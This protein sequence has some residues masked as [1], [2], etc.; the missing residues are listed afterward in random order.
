MLDLLRDPIW[1][2][3]AAIIAIIGT[4]LAL[5]NFLFPKLR[6]S[7][8]DK[9]HKGPLL[10]V[11]K[12][13]Q[14]LSR[15]LPHSKASPK[16]LGKFVL[17]VMV[18][19]I[20]LYYILMPPRQILGRWI[21]VVD[22]SD[23]MN[24]VVGEKSKISL[25]HEFLED[26]DIP[27]GV[28]AGLRIFGGDRSGK[29]DCE[30]TTLLI[31]P[32]IRQQAR[33][34]S[35][36]YEITVRGKTP[37]MKAIVEATNDF[38]L[39]STTPNKLIIL[40]SGVDNCDDNWSND[41]YTLLARLE[42]KSKPELHLIGVNIEETQQLEQLKE[43]AYLTDGLYYDVKNVEDIPD[44]SEAIR[45]EKNATYYMAR[46]DSYYDSGEY[47]IAIASYNEAIR[48]DAD[49][50]WAYNNRGN[51]YYRKGEFD[52]AISEFN[53]A[54]ADYDRA[55][56]LDPSLVWVY[57][58][59]GNAYNRTGEYDQAITDYNEAIELNSNFANAHS[60]RGW[61]YN[62]KGEY[63]KA[64]ADL[65]RAISL[66]PD[67][68][69]AYNNRGNSYYQKG[70]YDKAIMDLSRSIDLDSDLAWAYLNRGNSYYQRGEFDLAIADY[71]K[72]LEL[73]NNL[74]VYKFA[75]ERL[76]ELSNN[77]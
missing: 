11:G 63:D 58:N 71:K 21:Y 42:L 10:V 13:I 17:F 74:I 54:I 15:I 9:I 65:D 2:G 24:V 32:D 12:P 53:K 59:R 1:Q 27:D 72:V 40:T 73:N 49:F 51:A 34:K 61:A 19:G 28:E 67:L 20:A 75:E 62:E 64:I 29:V 22:V 5:L 50:A 70:E 38:D 25:A 4:I 57:N 45:D 8:K 77:P 68:A 48:L 3:F 36:L 37:L 18:I 46:G 39:S 76:N 14:V 66:D 33:I 26:Q 47:D 43:V 16:G 41:L 60:G 6:N 23:E 7:L 69:W 31:E 55:I 56:R 44:V 52:Q 35:E 30:N